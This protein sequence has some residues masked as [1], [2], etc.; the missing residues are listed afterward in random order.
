MTLE[1]VY[2]RKFADVPRVQSVTGVFVGI[3]D[4]LARVNLQGS[5]VDVKCD[6][7]YPPVPGMPVRV[8]TVN[9]VMRVVG[10]AKPQGGRGVVSASLSGGTRARITVDGAVFELP[11]MAPYSPVVSDTVVVNWTSGHILGEEA[12][13]PTPDPPP[14]TGGGGGGAFSGLLVQ[15][16]DSGRWST[17]SVN[18]FGNSDVW[19]GTTTQGAWFYSGGFSVLAGANVTGVEIYLPLIKE[20]NNL[21]FGLHPHA[22][23]PGGSPGI[24]T[25][26]AHTGARSGWVGLPSV[27]GNILRDNPSWG[28]GVISPGGGNNQWVGR[29]SDPMSGALRFAGTR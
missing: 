7:W 1:E 15:S 14:A 21:S 3:V 17:S 4:G 26:S 20:Q 12:A 24:D 25:L 2:A 16:Q 18:W 13:A 9:G 10:P 28:V 29:G 6:G 19:T 23:R 22:S 11:V 8:D 5:T 27:W